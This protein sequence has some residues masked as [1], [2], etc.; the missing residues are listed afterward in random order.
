M[1]EIKGIISHWGAIFDTTFIRTTPKDNV[2][3]ICLQGDQDP[4]VPYNVGPPF[5]LPI[6]PDVYGSLPITERMADI[7]IKTELHDFVGYGHEPWLL[8]PQLIDTCYVYE[9]PFLYSVLQPKPLVVTGDS[10]V[11]LN[12][13][14]QYS[15][16]NTPGSTYCWNV[17]GGAILTNTNNVITVD[18]VTP[19]LHILTVRELDR[20]QVNGPLDSFTVDVIN[21]PVAAFGDSILHTQATFSDS[22]IGAISWSYSFGD[23]TSSAQPDPTHNYSSQGTFTVRLIVSNGYCA[24][25]TYRSLTTDTCP[26]GAAI[27]Y[28]VSGDT[29]SF[30]AEPS[31]AVSYDWY[32]GDGDSTMT[33]DPS[34]EYYH[35]QNYLVSLTVTTSNDCSLY[36]SVI[37]PFKPVN[38]GVD[39]ITDNSINI[40]PNP[41]DDILHI[42]PLNEA[43]DIS[44]YDLAGKKIIDQNV[45][46]GTN[47][48]LNFKEISSGIYILRISGKSINLNQKVVK[49]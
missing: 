7:G 18:W 12:D 43:A 24:D 48:S 5:S 6:F 44:V 20:D 45:E 37:I 42:S 27:S 41:T 33:T 14:G 3:T 39:N 1:P 21:H 22:S 38:N 31:G 4:I 29:I 16:V 11:C 35:S 36:T 30:S 19:G 10:I 34:H 32:F 2:P 25:T 49:R 17:T 40:Y 47:I 23:N 8:A 28:T 13:V 46:E 26:S 15:V 9:I